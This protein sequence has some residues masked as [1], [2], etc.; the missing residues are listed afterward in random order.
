MDPNDKRVKDL[1]QQAWSLQTLMNKPG[2]RL[3]E[4]VKR[5]TY[6]FSSK[7]TELATN[8]PYIAEDDWLE[9]AAEMS[10]ALAA[11]RTEIEQM[12]KRL[13]EE[14]EEHRRNKCYRA[15]VNGGYHVGD[16]QDQ[17][18]DAIIATSLSSSSGSAVLTAA[19]VSARCADDPEELS[20]CGLGLR[21]DDMLAVCTALKGTAG[22]Q[23]RVLDLSC[24]SLADTGIQR[25]VSALA[26][27]ACKQL[28]ELHVGSNAFGEMGSKILTDG[29]QPLRKNLAIHGASAG[30]AKAIVPAAAPEARSEQDARARASATTDGPVDGTAASVSGISACDGLEKVADSLSEMD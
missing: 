18:T 15:G 24:N 9:R 6:K 16:R 2:G 10:S 7:A 30:P 19:E 26:A 14:F 17:P 4:D 29:L 28:K 23:L 1:S 21:D 11:K 5:D 20:L 3:P 8:A 12:E 22:T 13:T 27:G 25:L